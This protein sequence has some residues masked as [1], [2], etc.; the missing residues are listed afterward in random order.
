[1]V[2]NKKNVVLGQKGNFEYKMSK[3]MAN[4]YLKGR[5]STDKN[6]HPQDYLCQIVNNE[7]GIK[8]NCTRVLFF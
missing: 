7:F 6:K 5:K 2:K 4:A 3:E 1:M 8:G